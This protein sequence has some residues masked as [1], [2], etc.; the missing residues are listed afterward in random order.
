MCRVVSDNRLLLRRL[1]VV[2]LFKD[3]RKSTAGNVVS[4][5]CACYAQYD[6]LILTIYWM[7]QSNLYIGILCL[8]FPYI[9]ERNKSTHDGGKKLKFYM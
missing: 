4:Y 1:Q 2:G 5:V 7:P 9:A 6:F 8:V 3:K